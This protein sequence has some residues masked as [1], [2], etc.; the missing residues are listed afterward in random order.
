[1]QPEYTERRRANVNKSEK[2]AHFSKTARK[3]FLLDGRKQK[4]AERARMEAYRRL[5]EKE[6]IQSQRLKEYDEAR[7]SAKDS[8]QARLDE[9][10]ADT[11]LTNNE[12]KKRKYN[13]KRKFA[14]T[15]T[16]EI[17]EKRKKR[18]GAVQEAEA[19]AQQ[20]QE[21]RKAKMEAIAASKKMKQKK[22][23]ERIA[24]NKLLSQRTKKGQPILSNQVS[25]LLDKLNK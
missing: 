8:L 6:G 10:D 24:K 1:M 16:N 17:L 4:D 13:L 23:N 9:V 3:E 11:T 19:L 18:Y 5:C 2:Q 15:T 21:A 22:I 12:K 25:L 7:T 20:R 14:A